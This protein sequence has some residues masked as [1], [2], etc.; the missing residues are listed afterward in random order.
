MHQLLVEQT[1][2][3]PGGTASRV[4]RCVAAC[5]VSSNPA[6]P[7]HALA[8]PE[9]RTTARTLPPTATCW[10]HRTGA[11]FT[12][13]E[14]KTP[15]AATDGPSLR[16]TATSALPEFF[17]PAATPAARKPRGAVTLMVLLRSR[18]GLP[19]RAG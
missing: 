14:V 9:F 2:I 4:A 7:V 8:P 10:L 17:R 15:A 19:S 13:F 1:A 12:R 18:S 6:G 11:A 3:S 16:T 5:R